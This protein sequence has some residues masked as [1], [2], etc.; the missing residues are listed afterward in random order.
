MWLFARVFCQLVLGQLS[1]MTK[2]KVLVA[3][4][5]P[6][7]G[8]FSAEVVEVDASNVASILNSSIPFL[9]DASFIIDDI[10]AL[11]LEVGVLQV[12]SRH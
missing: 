4:S 9:V 2:L 3:L 8:A 11:Y 12:L 6:L 1:E 10:R 5:K 7:P